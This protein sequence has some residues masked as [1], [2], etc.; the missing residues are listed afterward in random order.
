MKNLLL[1]FL[2]SFCLVTK[3]QRTI[4][5]TLKDYML[6]NEKMDIPKIL[7]FIY[8]E[9][10]K[11]IP[12]ITMEET[13]KKTFD[14]PSMEIKMW[15]LKYFNIQETKE[16][17]E[18]LSSKASYSMMMSMKFKDQEAIPE[19]EDNVVLNMFQNMY[20]K[21]NVK[22]SFE[23]NKFTIFSKKELFLISKKEPV[24]WKILGIEPNFKGIYKKI[25]PEKMLEYY[26]F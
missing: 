8:P 25:L 23:E 1:L 3:A 12:R 22:Y 20:G 10:F 15:D 6:A 16:F 24:D 5:E 9:F 11:V 18:I 17:A 21:E 4:E 7:D 14:D 2:L 19:N 13:F 26:G